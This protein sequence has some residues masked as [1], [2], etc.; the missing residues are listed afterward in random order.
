MPLHSMQPIDSTERRKARRYAISMRMELWT[1]SEKR[2]ATPVF[3]RTRD[4]SLRG[5]Y[6]FSSIER[7]VGSLLSFSVIF[8]KEFSGED[9]DLIA[10]FAR[11][12]R[13]EAH[14]SNAKAAFGIALAIEKTSHMHGE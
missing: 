4:V 6:Y 3:V 2:R 14:P 12:V 1:E 11:V 9:S 5:I 7:E 13:C 10:G 8:L